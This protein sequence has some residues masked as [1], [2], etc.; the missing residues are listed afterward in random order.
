MASY[1]KSS[2][3]FLL[4]L[5]SLAAYVASDAQFGGWDG[6]S[7]NG[8]SSSP[9]GSFGGSSASDFGSNVGLDQQKD[10]THP[11]AK[12]SRWITNN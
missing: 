2:I 12:F 1:S 11:M 9:A 10:R 5:V 7:G 4:F 8:W 6:S 3:V